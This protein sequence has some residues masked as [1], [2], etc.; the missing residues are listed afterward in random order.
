LPNVKSIQSGS[1][2]CTIIDD[3]ATYWSSLF[4][5]A[6]LEKKLCDM[7]IRCQNELFH[8]H[9][10]VLGLRSSK[11]E[12]MIK[13]RSS[14]QTKS[15]NDN[16]ME[17]E[18]NENQ[19]AGKDGQSFLTIDVDDIESKTM[20]YFLEYIYTG[21]IKKLASAAVSHTLIIDLLTIAATYEMP[22]LKNYAEYYLKDIIRVD[23]A[24]ELLMLS[25][26]MKSD[27]L[28]Q[29]TCDYI[30][31]NLGLIMDTTGWK[32]LK[33]SQPDLIDTILKSCLLM[34]K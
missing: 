29:T 26:H 23:N 10:L 32:Q 9:K 11:F 12:Q 15:T 21:G 24:C 27:C 1:N 33:A 13:E 28:K 2:S 4:Y 31:N 8:V 30:A 16:N 34:R 5:T 20:L 7:F 6:Y 18:A 19:T 22:D 3:P 14:S 25:E 17:T